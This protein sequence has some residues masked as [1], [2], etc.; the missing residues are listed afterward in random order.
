MRNLCN[1]ACT[2]YEHVYAYGV[3]IDVY[4]CEDRSGCSNRQYLLKI[5]NWAIY[6]VVMRHENQVW[7]SPASQ[8]DGEGPGELGFWA[9]GIGVN[10]FASSFDL[11]FSSLSE[12]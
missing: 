1:V 4:A 6:H 8:A 3:Y 11:L 2:E 9:C 7:D 5:P 12:A 10:V